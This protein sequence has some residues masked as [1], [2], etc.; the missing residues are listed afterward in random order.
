M[1]PRVLFVVG[2]LG[3]LGTSCLMPVKDHE[4][5]PAPVPVDEY[6]TLL[7]ERYLERYDATGPQESWVYDPQGVLQEHSHYRYNSGFFL[8]GVDTYPSDTVTTPE[9]QLSRLEFSYDAQGNTVAGESYHR[10]GDGLVLIA[11][12]TAEYNGQNAY[13]DYLEK[14]GEGNV[15]EHRTC[16]YDDTGQNY[17]VETYYSDAATLN[18]IEEFRCTYDTEESWKWSSES[19]YQKITGLDPASVYERTLT[20]RFSWNANQMYQQT[21]FDEAGS[22]IGAILYA[23]DG[24]AKRSRSQ[25]NQEGKLV[26]YRTY[27]YDDQGFCTELKNFHYNV[28]PAGV[29]EH[30][31]SSRLWDDETGS[32][33]EKAVY[34]RQPVTKALVA[35]ILGTG[36]ASHPSVP[37]CAHHRE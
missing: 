32:Y 26:R 12:F 37:L 24:T 1:S 34:T 33:Y 31:E 29:L 28:D 35:P 18:K 20:H 7:S 15:T 9:T 27:Q 11:S 6:R 23:F 5:S 36:L 25:L 3:L 13:T 19:H 2:L 14:D 16:T 30:R 17:L 8:V 4:P 22:M 10:L 21:D